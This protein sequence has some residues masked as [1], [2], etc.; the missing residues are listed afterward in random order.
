MDT[1]KIL[2]AIFVG[3]TIGTIS[4]AAKS[5]VDVERL[6]V[7]VDNMVDLIRETRDDVKEIKQYFL[8]EFRSLLV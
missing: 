5:Y 6:K 8:D 7:H 1:K 4:A 2:A 3:L